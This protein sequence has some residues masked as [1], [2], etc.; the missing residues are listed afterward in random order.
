MYIINPQASPAS[1]AR[2][3][4]MASIAHKARTSASGAFWPMIAGP[5]AGVQAKATSSATSS[6]RSKMR[7]SR[8][9]A[10]ATSP[11]I[12]TTFATKAI[13]MGI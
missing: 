5:V 7:V 11:S 12:R 10:T 4:R 8:S 2:S 1:R 6:D 3:R 9:P 13:P